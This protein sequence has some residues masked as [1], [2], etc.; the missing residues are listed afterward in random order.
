MGE[1]SPDGPVESSGFERGPT[2]DPGPVGPPGPAGMIGPQGPQGERGSAAYVETFDAAPVWIVNHNLGRHP[3]TWA[4]STLGN[5][6]IDVCVQHVTMNQS[7]VYF[8][9]PVAGIVRFT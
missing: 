6:E 5:V 1:F 7:R 2:G 9:L 3:H 8:D 4:V